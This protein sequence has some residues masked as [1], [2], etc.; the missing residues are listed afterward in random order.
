MRLINI[1][2]GNLQSV[3]VANEYLLARV[4]ESDVVFKPSIIVSDPILNLMFNPIPDPIFDPVRLRL[5]G[6]PTKF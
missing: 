3:N 4:L 2:V 5:F 1:N 6:C